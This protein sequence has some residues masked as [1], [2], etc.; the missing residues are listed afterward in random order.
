MSLNFDSYINSGWTIIF[1]SAIL[2]SESDI[3]QQLFLI[4]PAYTALTDF[5]LS[6]TLE[7]DYLQQQFLID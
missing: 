4:D 6:A 2:K 1:L 5:S 3:S 7:G